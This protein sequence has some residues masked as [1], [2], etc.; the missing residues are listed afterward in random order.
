MDNG[1]AVCGQ[2]VGNQAA[3]ATPPQ[4]FGA[5]DGGGGLPGG[6]QENGKPRG[7]LRCGHIVGVAVEAPVAPECVALWRDIGRAAAQ[8]AEFGN[9]AV[10]DAVSGEGLPQR[11]PVVLR[12]AVRAG[13]FAHIGNAADAVFLQQADKFADGAAAVA[14]GIDGIHVYS[15]VSALPLWAAIW[16]VLSLLI[17]YCGCCGSARWVWPL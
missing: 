4:G 3:V 16:S 6:M 8:A 5:H 14:D 9:V 12:M 1:Q 10:G 13:Q 17:S 15:R 2:C 7:E 11:I